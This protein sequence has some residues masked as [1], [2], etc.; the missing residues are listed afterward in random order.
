[1]FP[2]ASLK[3]NKKK[4]KKIATGKK[5]ENNMEVGR[6]P[7]GVCGSGVGANSIWCCVCDRWCHKRCSGLRSLKKVVDFE[8][9]S[10]TRSS[11]GEMVD[12]EMIEVNRVVGGKS[13]QL[14]YLRDDLRH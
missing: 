7:C 10:C 11:R 13:K 14:C 9:P 5:I 3:V 6:Y 8:C 1:M 12:M 2:S 4:S